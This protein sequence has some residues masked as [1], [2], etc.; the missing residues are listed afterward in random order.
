MTTP[1]FDSNCSRRFVI[2]FE[3]KFLIRRSLAISLISIC[4]CITD[5]IPLSQTV[6]LDSIPLSQTVYLDITDSVPPL[7]QT[8]YLDSI[9][10][11]Q[12]VYLDS[13]PLSQTVYLDITDSVPPLS[14]TVY[15]DSVPLSQ[16]V[17]LDITDSVPPLSQ[18]VYLD[19]IPLSQTV[20]LD[21]VRLLHHCFCFGLTL[22]TNLHRLIE[23][24]Q[25]LLWIYLLPTLVI[26][27][28]TAQHSR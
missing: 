14:Q 24:W 4:L 10:L 19:S 9:P 13:V 22:L 8:V 5:S 15:L 27:S 11:S 18:T 17:Y 7:S 23:Q 25:T 2:R 28:I 3:R 20:Y 26:L 21:S 1:R 6:Y 16:T 12:T